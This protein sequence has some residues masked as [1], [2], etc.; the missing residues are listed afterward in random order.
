VIDAT[1]YTSLRFAA[2]ASA[3]GQRYA[4][5]LHDGANQRLSSP[6]QLVN[7]GGEPRPDGWTVYQ[8]PLAELGASGKGISG[9]IIQDATGGAQPV[10]YVDD[11]SLSNAPITPRGPDVS[12]VYP[13][14]TGVVATVFWV[15]EP[16]NA[17]SGYI[18]NEVSAWDSAWLEHFGGIDDPVNRNGYHPAGFTPKENPFY[19]D[20]PYNDFDSRGVRKPDAYAV[21]PWANDRFWGDTESMLKNRWVKVMRN[22]V[23]CYAQWEDAGPTHYNDYPYV[24]GTARPANET[25]PRFANGA[26]MDVSPAVRDCLGFQG[27]NNA[28]NRLD[29]QFVEER[30]VPDGPWKTIITRSGVHWP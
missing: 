6:R 14:H 15:G 24:F 21:V 26:G 16:A 23:V 20:V 18:T 5:Y 28:T 9:I 19:F 25:A 30:D 27:I 8:I 29:W 10:L 17:D 11:V 7:F 12:R 13:V 1:P 2:R 4:V 22:G 3:A